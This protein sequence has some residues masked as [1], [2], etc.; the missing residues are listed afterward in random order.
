[1]W[2][3]NVNSNS[4]RGVDI[5]TNW[6]HCEEK[7]DTFLNWLNSVDNWVQFTMMKESG[8]GIDFFDIWV[9]CKADGGFI[10]H[11]YRKPTHRTYFYADLHHYPGQK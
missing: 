5:F 6:L 8:G 11:V 7:L 10:H 4:N 9:E 1:M 2:N 3:H